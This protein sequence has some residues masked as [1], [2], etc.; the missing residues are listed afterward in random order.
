[1]LKPRHSSQADVSS[2]YCANC[3]KLYFLSFPLFFVGKFFC[4]LISPLQVTERSSIYDCSTGSDP[5]QV[6]QEE[7]KSRSSCYREE[8]ERSEKGLSW[9][10]E[11]DCRQRLPEN[12]FQIHQ[13]RRN[14]NFKSY[15]MNPRCFH[16]NWGEFCHSH[17]SS[18]LPTFTCSYFTTELTKISRDRFSSTPSSASLAFS[19]P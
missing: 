16:Q 5:S 8:R 14:P 11:R 7:V 4:H 10:L 6:D 15:L 13:Q 12:L 17:W 2:F 9:L 1:M 3:V 19:L 18:S